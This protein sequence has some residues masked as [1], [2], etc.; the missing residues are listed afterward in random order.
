MDF[1][2]L[3]KSNKFTYTMPKEAEFK[4]LKEL[5]PAYTYILVT[6]HM[7]T[8]GKF[9]TYPIGGVVCENTGEVNWVSFPSH[10]NDI[11]N[12]IISNE[13]FVAGVNDDKC[14]FKVKSFHSNKYNRTG[15]GIEFL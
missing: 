8:K 1:K 11:F 2:T 3:N 9:G 15:Y 13:D 10:L 12:A 6:A 14:K 5:N 4:N 7:N